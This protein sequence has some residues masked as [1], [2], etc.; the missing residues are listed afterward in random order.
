MP[1]K[2]V[3]TCVCFLMLVEYLPSNNLIIHTIYSEQFP[4]SHLRGIQN[5]WD[6]KVSYRNQWVGL[7][8]GPTTLYLTKTLRLENHNMTTK[9]LSR[10]RKLRLS[11]AMK[12][13]PRWSIPRRR[14][15]PD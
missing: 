1:G 13:N 5:Y 8:G 4:N 14:P 10:F 11:R 12:N 7:T 9:R 15:I 3:I 2:N 6:L